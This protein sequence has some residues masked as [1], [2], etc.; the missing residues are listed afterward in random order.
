MYNVTLFNEN[1]AGS[2]T[3]YFMFQN[4]CSQHGHGLGIKS[5]NMM[6][7]CGFSWIFSWDEYKKLNSNIRHPKSYLNLNIRIIF[8]FISD[9]SDRL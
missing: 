7:K 6:R 2:M 1:H 5:Q 4:N 8:M 3:M 9:T